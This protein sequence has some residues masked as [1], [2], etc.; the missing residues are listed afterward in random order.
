MTPRGAVAPTTLVEGLRDAIDRFG[1]R[2]A[3]SWRDGTLTYAELGRRA[4]EVGERLAGLGVG[5]GDRVLCRVANRPELLVCALATWGRGAI[6]AAVDAGLTDAETAWHVATTGPAVLVVENG[7]PP[8]ADGMRV[9]S[10]DRLAALGDGTPRGHGGAT[11]LDGPGAD[12]PA[13]ILFT[14]GTTAEPKAVVRYQGQVLDAWQRSGALLGCGPD[15]V[16]LVHLPLSHG[17]GF[18]LAMA[19]L[20]TGGKVVVLDRFS[21]DGTIDTIRD[22]GVTVLH[23]TPTHFTLLTDRCAERGLALPTLRVGMGSA[24]SFS[25]ELIARV[26]DL[27]G[28]DLI[29]VYGSSEGLGWVT[30]DRDAMLDGSV[31]VP[32]PATARIVGPDGADVAPGEV[33]EIC[34]R[35]RASFHYWGQPRTTPGEAESPWYHTGDVGRMDGLGRVYVLGRVK[36]QVSRGGLRVDP[37]EVE[38][39]L[40]RHPALADV[41]VVGVPERVLGQVVCACVVTRDGAAVTLDQLRGFLAGSLA[42]HKLPERLCVVDAIPRTPLGKTDRGQLQSL[43]IRMMEVE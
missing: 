24:A 43:A 37:G 40:A 29:L 31:G 23:G 13:V 7:G 19:A 38:A 18:G 42:R 26:F 9:V 8:E 33:G 5:R 39:L 28:M 4:A 1:D 3:V 36:H 25:P 21:V 6:H 32:P 35:R 27:L 15:D 10:L 34:I 12:D 17:F 20:L 22:E 16:H 14:S 41:A 11:A 30:R 2:P